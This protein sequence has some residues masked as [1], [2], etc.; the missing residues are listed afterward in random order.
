MICLRL[1][2]FY[3]DL[4][5]LVCVTRSADNYQAA[6]PSVEN[7]PI[8]EQ[9]TVAPSAHEVAQPTT[10]GKASETAKVTA[11]E[12]GTSVTASE[13]WMNHVSVFWPDLCSS[14]SMRVL[15]FC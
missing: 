1:S 8:L 10:T 6:T 2:H 13:P 4:L 11:P 12:I 14:R 7:V 9:A 15:K 5:F 3:A